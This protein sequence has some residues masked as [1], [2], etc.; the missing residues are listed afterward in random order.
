MA[1]KDPLESGDGLGHGNSSRLL[2]HIN[3]LTAAGAASGDSFTVQH[4]QIANLSGQCSDNRWLAS[5]CE[6]PELPLV[7]GRQILAR[8]SPFIQ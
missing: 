5:P 1:D 8:F 3:L 7:P 2:Q 6:A 4:Q